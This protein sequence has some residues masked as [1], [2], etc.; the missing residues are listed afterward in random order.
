MPTSRLR[1]PRP[2]LRIAAPD[3]Q[4]AD[5]TSHEDII[6]DPSLQNYCSEIS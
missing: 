6:Q 5:H 2:E 1:V 3:L 4:I